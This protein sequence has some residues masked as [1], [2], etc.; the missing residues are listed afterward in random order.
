MMK[1]IFIVAF[2]LIANSL[3]AQKRYDCVIILNP[4]NGEEPERFLGSLKIVNDS[5]VTLL[6]NKNTIELKWDD[7]KTIKFRNHNGFSRTVLPLSIL[8]A[9][10]AIT[11]ILNTG[12]GRP[13][14]GFITL[15]PIIIPLATILYSVVTIPVGMI[16]YT[17]FRNHIYAINSYDDFIKL[18]QSSVKYISK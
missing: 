3:I 15:E 8:T 14:G 10:T 11:I 2:V 18:K 6:S 1:V 7:I 13:S 16:I 12:P 5:S 9:A 4:F 17:L